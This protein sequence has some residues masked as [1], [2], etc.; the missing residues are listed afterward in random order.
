MKR[1]KR[2]ARNT[3]IV[4]LAAA[5]CLHLYSDHFGFGSADMQVGEPGIG[6]R[7]GTE[8][9]QING[10]GY[11]S[12]KREERREGTAEEAVL[13]RPRPRQRGGAGSRAKAKV[14]YIDDE[15]IESEQLRRG[16]GEGVVLGIPEKDSSVPKD[17]KAKDSKVEDKERDSGA[18]KGPSH[19][20]ESGG[21]PAA[22]DVA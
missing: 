16:S 9:F 6:R 22:L 12:E 2:M 14:D 3:L 18:Q 7:Q 11:R 8:E 15:E 19:V 17:L 1:V 13:P 20:G 5:A 10:V 21:S 4:I